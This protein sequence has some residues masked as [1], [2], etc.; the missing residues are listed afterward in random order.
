MSLEQSVVRRDRICLARGS[1]EPVISAAS[2]TAAI[3]PQ[4]VELFRPL[5][6]VGYAAGVRAYQ[7]AAGKLTARQLTTH[8]TAGLEYFHEAFVPELKRRMEE[9]S[10][11]AW[12]LQW[13]IAF[14]AGNDVDFM[15]HLVDAVAARGR[16]A[17]YPGDWHGFRVGSTHP[18]QIAWDSSGRSD[19]ACLCIP[20]V[21]NGHVTPPMLDFLKASSACLLNL[22]LF[23][24]LS[25]LDR[26]RTARELLPILDKAVLSISFSRGF[27]LTASQLGVFLVPSSHPY[28]EQFSSQWNWFTYFYNALAAQAFLEFDLR[29]AQ[30]VDRVRAQWVQSWLEERGLPAVT[31]GSYYVKSFQV[32]GDL[33]PHFAPLVRDD[34]V[35][36]CFKPPQA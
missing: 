13:H 17:L 20:S 29:A 23:P 22:N 7:A 30:E 33:P 34:L 31:G 36:L 18:D 35:R 15:A 27:G 19:L 11:G 25:P 14:A 6:P 28:R 12:S 21:R 5:L 10:G 2:L 4:E 16:V 32:A 24:T 3:E 9:L 1:A 8:Y 26:E